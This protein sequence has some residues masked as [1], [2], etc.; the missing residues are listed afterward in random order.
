MKLTLPS[1]SRLSPSYRRQ[2]LHSLAGVRRGVGRHIHSQ[3]PCANRKD[4]GFGLSEQ[5][6]IEH[7]PYLTSLS[8]AA[9]LWALPVLPA[10]ADALESPY[11]SP[12][13]ESYYVSL[14]LF[15]ITLP[16]K[17]VCGYRHGVSLLNRRSYIYKCCHDF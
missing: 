1:K 10:A 17:S 6:Y 15:I 4:A 8:L 3:M 9:C 14:G 5:E 7:S 16:G 12:P 11:G 13:A 2:A